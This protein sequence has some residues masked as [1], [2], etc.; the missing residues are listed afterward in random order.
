MFPG[1]VARF[2]VDVREDTRTMHTEVDVPNPGRVLLPGLYADAT[3]TLEKKD[4]VIA[5]PLQAVDQSNGKTTVDVVDASSKIEIRPFA[6]GI[7]TATYIEVLSGLQEGE[8]VVV[9]DRS[10]LKANQPVQYKLT[11]LMQYHSSEE[12]R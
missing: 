8:L 9:S 5:A 11:D 1:K 7:Q 2:S 10:G 4:N 3:I 12:Q 6:A